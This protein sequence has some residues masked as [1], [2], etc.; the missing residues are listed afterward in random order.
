M[1]ESDGIKTYSYTF[2]NAEAYHRT[3]DFFVYMSEAGSLAVTS[4]R[5]E[6]TDWSPF[7]EIT[8]GVPPPTPITGVWQV[9]LDDLEYNDSVTL[10]LTTLASVPTSYNWKQPGHNS[11]YSF[12]IYGYCED[13]TTGGVEIWGTNSLPVPDPESTSV[14]EPSS[15]MA[16]FGLLATASGIILK[17]RC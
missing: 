3:Y 10:W 11:N 13:G 2:T 12:R 7:H 9:G 17:R 6:W 8:W 16:L 1:T 5:Q 14:P 15:F 4:V